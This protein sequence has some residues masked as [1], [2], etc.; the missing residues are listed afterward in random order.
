MVTDPRNL[1]GR[2]LGRYR[3][4]AKLG[5]GGMGVVYDAKDEVLGRHVAL[6][7]VSGVLQ[8][9]GER[10]LR[11]AREARAAAAFTHPNAVAIFDAGEID[12]VAFIAMELVEGRSLRSFVGAADVGVADRIRWLA[13]VARALAAAHRLGIIHR[14]IKPDNVM[15]RN[16][17][18][19]KVLDFG[20]AGFTEPDAGALAATLDVT[21]AR[22]T[23]DG[24]RLGTPLYMA[25]EQL[26]GNPLDA[27]A[28]QFSWGVV[29]YELLSG[30]LPWKGEAIQIALQNPHR[31]AAPAAH[32]LPGDPAARRDRDRPRAGEGQGRPLPHD[33]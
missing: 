12:G 10:R 28:D 6:K 1:V 8:G 15:V 16:D 22:L 9:D 17:G 23:T 5:E 19:A 31:H 30:R 29:A 33:G 32:A 14:D 7:V 2:Q 26:Q 20:V 24:V 4:Q 18:Q 11:F 21:P 3:V 25:P 27:R 13:D